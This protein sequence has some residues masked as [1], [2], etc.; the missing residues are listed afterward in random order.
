MPPRSRQQVGLYSHP[1]RC[2]TA[3]ASRPHAQHCNT[4]VQSPSAALQ[5]RVAHRRPLRF[6][7]GDR[8]GRPWTTLPQ[9]QRNSRKGRASP[10]LLRPP[11]PWHRVP[12]SPTWPQPSYQA[13][14]PHPAAVEDRACMFRGV[15][16][17]DL[18]L[19]DIGQLDRQAERVPPHFE[20]RCGT[21]RQPRD[22]ADRRS[23][24]KL[25]PVVGPPQR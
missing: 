21:E 11:R 12:L 22:R 17:E 10:R 14:A 3:L 25:T 23:S 6:V 4:P 8:T 7:A 15:G 18:S 20:R 13:S 2:S 5:H 9:T 16:V 24:C 1:R 19:R